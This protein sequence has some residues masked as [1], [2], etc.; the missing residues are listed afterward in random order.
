MFCKICNINIY[1]ATVIDRMHHLDL[2][3]CNYQITFTCDLLKSKYGHLILD[4]IDNRLANIPRHSGL[5][6]FKNGIQTANIMKIII[7]VLNDLT[8]DNDSNKILIKVY[9]DWNNMYLMSRYE[10]FSEKDLENFEII[11]LFLNN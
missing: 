2:G 3:L 1:E 7:F 8:E 11:L 4:K 6:I 10:E 5:K 9:E